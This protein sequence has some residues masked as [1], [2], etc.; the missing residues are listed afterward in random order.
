M[1]RGWGR[2]GEREMWDDVIVMSFLRVGV[3]GS[4]DL[5]WHLIRS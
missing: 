5:F 4:M 3:G 1:E 2:E